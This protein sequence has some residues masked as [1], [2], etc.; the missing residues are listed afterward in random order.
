MLLKVISSNMLS[1]TDPSCLPK[2]LVPALTGGAL[3]KTGE[4]KGPEIGRTM[5][6][7]N[8][9]LWERPE[10]NDA[11]TLILLAQSLKRMVYRPSD[12]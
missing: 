6:L 5:E 2:P 12:E 1:V 4:F 7:L 8:F 10:L 9:C 11:Q 3:L